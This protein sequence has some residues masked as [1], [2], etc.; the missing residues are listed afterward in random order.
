MWACAAHR[1]VFAAALLSAAWVALEAG[2]P[3]DEPAPQFTAS[4]LVDKSLLK[5]P[6]YTIDEP[7]VTE[8]YFHQFAITSDYGPFTAIG[9]SVLT[10]RIDEIRAIAALHEVS[11]SEVFL[12]SAGGAVV[13]LGKGVANVVTK[14]TETAKG[15]GGGI[16]RFGV[17]LGRASKRAMTNE[18]GAETGE[19][20]PEGAAN[21]LLGVSSAMRN[22]A[23]KVGADPYTTNI[24]LRN[25]L[26]GIADVD[27]AGSIVTKVV[28]PVPMVVGTAADV[29]GL[30][31]SKDPEELRKYNEGLV[32]K[33]GASKDV[34]SKFFKNGWFTL[35]MQTRLIA[36]LH[37]VNRPG[38][39]DYLQ[40]ASHADD[41]REALFFV[42]SAEMLRRAH[43]KAP[44]TRVLDDSQAVV[45]LAGS[46]ALLLAPVDYVRSTDASRE[47]L[48][49][50][51]GRARSELK[52][53]SLE[54]RVTGRVS[55]EAVTVAKGAGWTV[56]QNAPGR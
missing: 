38:C 24:T 52:A 42:E 32:T 6:H 50:V 29:G 35:T 43:A 15:I 55:A 44:V 47:V 7:V 36:A 53:S 22:W 20:A 41:E 3:A 13:D 5:G 21:T 51:A 18:G 9:R 37:H 46:K 31:W 25:A 1:V 26:K 14:P 40:T 19:S 12:K 45:A 8:G 56:V 39:A 54:L 16:K 30:V 23:R 33:L 10:T 49:E 27:V 2:A 4:A 17:N 48:T 28:V 34:A 11:K